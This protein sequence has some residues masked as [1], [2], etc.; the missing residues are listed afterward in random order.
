MRVLTKP[1]VP[2]PP[3]GPPPTHWIAVAHPRLAHHPSPSSSSSSGGGIGRMA[4]VGGRISGPG[5]GLGASQLAGPLPPYRLPVAAMEQ[6]LW[7][8]TGCQQ[9]HPCLLE[10]A[11]R[12]PKG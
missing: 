2:A 7:E 8:E 4:C 10:T 12:A 1:P 9:A 3:L 6:S 11:Q 5:Q